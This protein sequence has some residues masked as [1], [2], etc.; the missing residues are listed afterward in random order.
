QVLLKE[1]EILLFGGP[2]SFLGS[3]PVCEVESNSQNSDDPAGGVAQRLQIVKV[4]SPVD[5]RLVHDGI[6]AACPLV[7]RHR[8]LSLFLGGE[9]VSQRHSDHVGGLERQILPLGS[10]EAGK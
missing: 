10:I 9:K 3:L 1:A 4:L 7:R 8:D 2:Q 5:H 6:A